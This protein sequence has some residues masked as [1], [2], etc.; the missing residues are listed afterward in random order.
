[1]LWATSN[2]FKTC[3]NSSFESEKT[4]ML[5]LWEMLWT[6]NTPL[7]TCESNSFELETT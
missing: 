5:N 2:S 1:M 7:Y 3:E 6:K 4:L